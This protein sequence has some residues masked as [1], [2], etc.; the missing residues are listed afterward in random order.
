MEKKVGFTAQFK[1][2]LLDDPVTGMFLCLLRRQ[3][4]RD[5]D[6]KD[7]YPLF[8]LQSYLKVLGHNSVVCAGDLDVFDRNVRYW[9]LLEAFRKFLHGLNLTNENS[10]INLEMIE[11]L[12]DVYHQDSESIMVQIKDGSNER[13][14]LDL[15]S[16]EMSHMVQ[17]MSAHASKGLEFDHVYL[18]GIYTN[19]RDKADSGLFG[20]MPGSFN[21]YED[22]SIRDKQPSPF[23]V[24]ENELGKYKNFS[25]AKRLFYVACT[26]AKKKLSWVNF[27]YPEKAFS[28]PKN[29]WIDGLNA[30]LNHPGS[31]ESLKALDVK[32][33]SESVPDDLLSSGSKPQLPLFFH[34]PV[35]I[36]SKGEGKVELGLLAELSV[37]RL[38]SLIDCPRKLYFE[39][40]L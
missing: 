1:I 13:V 10:D 6:T 3:Y 38:N 11:T 5:P 37:T 12:S 39:N 30:W 26:R 31:G 16:G 17:I 24:F 4:D 21:W 20:E 29:S 23:Y 33:V 25:E 14:S 22:L 36:F 40:I 35:G 18:A 19:G 7:R 28:I 9:G 34:D 8:L 15:R 32:D 2:D 27:E